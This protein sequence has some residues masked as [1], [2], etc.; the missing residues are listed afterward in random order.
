MSYKINFTDTTTPNDPNKQFLT[1]EDL[2]LNTETSLVFVG[3]NYPGYAKFIG[4]NFLHLLENFASEFEPSNP[5]IG[6]LW[7][8]T[9]TSQLKVRNNGTTWSEASGIKRDLIAPSIATP[10]D[11]WVNPATQQ[12]YLFNASNYNKAAPNTPAESPN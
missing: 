4:E 11:L 12:L 3:K 1:V 5:V 6:Q 2:S 10:G 7:Y 9:S 8:D